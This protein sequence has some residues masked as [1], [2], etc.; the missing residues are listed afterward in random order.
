M[1]VD[2]LTRPAR[3]VQRRASRDAA[4][5]R[6]SPTHR[7]DDAA[8]RA[9]AAAVRAHDAIRSAA[10]D[11]SEP[12]DDAAS[13][14]AADAAGSRATG[15]A[16]D[17]AA[18]AG[19]CAAGARRLRH[20]PGIFVGPSFASQGYSCTCTSAFLLTPAATLAPQS[21]A[22]TPWV[23]EPKIKDVE[24]GDAIGEVCLDLL[25]RNATCGRAAL[26]EHDTEDDQVTEHP[27]S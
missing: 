6:P 24:G 27:S 7:D 14:D 3:A 5:G 20:A 19:S 25:L 23:E 9:A 17:D 13:A 8:G 22:D 1:Q 16:D 4:R 18:D 2:A 26:L 11:V 12:A 15:A 21:A 10:D